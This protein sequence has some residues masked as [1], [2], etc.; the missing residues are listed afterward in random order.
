MA[1]G[2]ARTATHPSFWL[3]VSWNAHEKGAKPWIKRCV[4]MG[5]SIRLSVWSMCNFFKAGCAG[6]SLT[7]YIIVAPCS[8]YR[9]G[10]VPRILCT[11]A[12]PLHTPAG[13]HYCGTCSMKYWTHGR[14]CDNV[15]KPSTHGRLSS[16]PLYFSVTPACQLLYLESCKTQW[17]AGVLLMFIT[18]SEAGVLVWSIFRST[19]SLLASINGLN[20]FL[21]LTH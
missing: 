10:P 3:W 9:Q 19:S 13:R 6:C 21:Q 15:C 16:C 1:I 14:V 11:R 8:Y 7:F 18:R 20:V 17:P 4:D 12:T 2:P 5:Y